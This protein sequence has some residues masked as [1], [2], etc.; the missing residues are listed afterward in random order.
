METD[1]KKCPY[2]A[3]IIKAEAIKCKYCWSELSLPEQKEE[4]AREL[5]ESTLD[6]ADE[7]MEIFPYGN[8]YVEDKKK[9]GGSQQLEHASEETILSPEEPIQAGLGKV[10]RDIEANGKLAFE[11]GEVVEIE[12]IE[13]DG[14]KRYE[15]ISI[16]LDNVF[17]V[18]EEDIITDN[19][20]IQIGLLTRICGSFPASAGLP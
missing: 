3:E 12:P 9:S 19:N 18:A 7:E 15:A 13:V 1:E 17:E 8:E 2:C 4:P 10:A 16:K 6:V 20:A 11:K 5:K 14:E